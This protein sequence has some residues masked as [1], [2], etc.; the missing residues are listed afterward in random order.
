MT[1][2]K[3]FLFCNMTHLRAKKENPTKHLRNFIAAKQPLQLCCGSSKLSS[4]YGGT[5]P[6]VRPFALFDYFYR[7]R[8]QVY[9]RLSQLIYMSLPFKSFY[10]I[11]RPAF[12]L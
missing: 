7:S 8:G 1:F 2:S 5:I 10:L 9:F 4:L 6:W 3:H 11:S 12:F